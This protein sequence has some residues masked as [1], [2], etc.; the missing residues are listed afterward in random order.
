M[1]R[2]P[3]HV[4]L[5]RTVVPELRVVRIVRSSAIVIRPPTLI[6]G[7]Y[8][9]G[10]FRGAGAEALGSSYVALSDVD[11]DSDVLVIAACSDDRCSTTC[12]TTVWHNVLDEI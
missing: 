1:L 3:V 4:L 5:V 7:L 10:H 8:R 6:G 2:T 12:V 9:N 11:I